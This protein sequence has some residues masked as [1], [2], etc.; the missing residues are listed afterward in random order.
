VSLQTGIWT[1]LAAIVLVAAFF[2]AR[3]VRVVAQ[4]VTGALFAVC[5]LATLALI[6]GGIT[7]ESKGGGVMLLFAVFPGIAAWISGHFFFAS[8]RYGALRQ[9]PVEDQR[10]ATINDY[11]ESLDSGLERLA[12]LKAERASF[13]IGSTRRRKLDAEIAHEERMLRLLPVLRPALDDLANYEQEPRR[14]I[15]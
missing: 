1:L 7:L 4:L 5:T 13:R 11:E 2:P 3:G 12:R 14:P 9:Q 15:A 10:R 6:V 8:R